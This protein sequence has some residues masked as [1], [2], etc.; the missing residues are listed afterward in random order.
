MNINE[1]KI[2]VR[3]SVETYLSRDEYGN[4]KIPIAAQRPV[5]LMGPPGIG[6]TA[7][8]QQIAQEMDIALVSYSMTHHT[9]QSALGLP[10]IKH[11]SYEGVEYD[12]S[13]YTMSEIIASIYDVMEKTGKKEGIL[14][15]DEIN[16]VSE[17][18]SPSMLQF[19]QYKTFGRHQVPEGWAIVTAG[20]P[21]EFNRSVREFDIAT[22][23]RMRVLKVDADYD[24]WRRY[25]VNVGLHSAIITYLDI[26]KTDFYAI[27]NTVDGKSYVTT[28]GWED[29]SK[30]LYIYEEKGFEI[31]DILIGQFLYNKKISRDFASYYDLFCKYKRDYHITEIL[32]GKVEKNII[33]QA[34]DAPFDERLSILGLL[35]DAV[36][37]EIRK[38]VRFETA[39]RTLQ[40]P[41]KDIKR[42][43][44]AREVRNDIQGVTAALSDKRIQL[45]DELEKRKKSGTIGSLE[46]EG[47]QIAT[48]LINNYIKEITAKEDVRKEVFE[49]VR[50]SYASSAASLKEDIIKIKSHLDNLFVFAQKAF[51]EGNEMLILVT[52]LTVNYDS[53]KFIGQKG[54]EKYFKYNKKFQVYERLAKIDMQLQKIDLEQIEEQSN[55]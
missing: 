17:T 8:M 43:V 52:D 50:E 18:L 16:C 48:G 53:A 2:Q 25:A 23:D 21:P 31:T 47:L 38:N 9:R 24:T 40:T 20:N 30:T 12:I 3:Q 13:E 34:K 49:A 5:F 4:V 22:M 14:F 55:V 36:Q 46:R 29:L 37:D 10:V 27:E 45:E 39:M 32:E 42:A 35:L 44:G 41:L 26:K 11:K 7:I 33:K 6:K 28:R 51:G 15:L 19:L 54:C 1:A